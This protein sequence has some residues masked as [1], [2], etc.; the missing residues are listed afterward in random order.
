MSAPFMAGPWEVT[1]DVARVD[2]GP[3]YFCATE[4]ASSDLC[5]AAVA[6]FASSGL[7]NALDPSPQ[8]LGEV[9]GVSGTVRSATW[10]YGL[11]WFTTQRAARPTST[12]PGGHSAHFEGR[13]TRDGRTVRFVSDVDV[14]PMI[15]GSLAVQGA[16]VS[17]DLRAATARLDLTFDARAWWRGVDFDEVAAISGDPAVVP[18]SSR[19]HNA[20][21]IAMTTTGVPT[22]TWSD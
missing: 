6:E 3:V 22:F 4:A 13:A 11:T 15:Q 10:D 18:T 20:V 21:V 2:I 16:R 17:G 14:A 19:A 12:A 1:L 7:V 8:R 9:T 5:P